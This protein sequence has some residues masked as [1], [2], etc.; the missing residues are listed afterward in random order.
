MRILWIWMIKIYGKEKGKK[1]R[2]AVDA[3]SLVGSSWECR[4]CAVLDADEYFEQ[5][6]KTHS[7]Y[8]SN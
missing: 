5:L 3:Y 6:K 1:Y 7:N 2:L 4:D 8:K